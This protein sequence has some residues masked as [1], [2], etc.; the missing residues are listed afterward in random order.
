MST[1]KF[2][3]SNITV[4]TYSPRA[5]GETE[6][7]SEWKEVEYSQFVTFTP[8]QRAEFVQALAARHSQVWLRT[9]VYGRA[10]IFVKA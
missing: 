3:E 10:R 6:A 5:S 8:A 9:A 2:T 1:Y 4:R 7:N